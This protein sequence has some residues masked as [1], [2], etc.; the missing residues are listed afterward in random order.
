MID[1]FF[2]VEKPKW[3]KALIGLIPLCFC[4]FLSITRV[5]LTKDKFFLFLVWNLILAIVPLILSSALYFSKKRNAVY[6]IFLIGLWLLFFPNAPYIITDII[7]L[8]VTNKR[9]QWFDLILL[10][11][12]A[13]SGLLYGFLS[14]QCIEY[15]L[16]IKF[17]VKHTWW[18]ASISLFL[19]SF[20]IYLG[21]FLRWNSWDIFANM[22][23][24]MG[25]VLVRLA[26]PIIHHDIW[27]FTFLFGLF[28][29]VFYFTTMH[30][31]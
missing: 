16:Q 13:A 18:F 19:A 26:N 20:G 2:D 28:L 22:R 4:F 25:D 29:N 21:R 27:W 24:V 3:T 1:D 11:S 31:R 5:I 14:L 23:E 7:H 6:A 12:Y 8:R 15:T 30:R 10:T 9:F 17:N